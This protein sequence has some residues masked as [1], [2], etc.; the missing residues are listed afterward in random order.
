MY[1][2]LVTLAKLSL[3]SM[4]VQHRAARYIHNILDSIPYVA[5]TIYDNNYH[6]DSP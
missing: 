5:Y 4:P 6:S 1:P 2:L 3:L